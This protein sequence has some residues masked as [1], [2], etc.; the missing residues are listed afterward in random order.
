MVRKRADNSDY[1]C[2]MA[3]D[4]Y[5][6]KG[7]LKPLDGVGSMVVNNL[8]GFFL[9]ESSGFDNGNF[10]SHSLN[11]AL[12]NINHLSLNIVIPHCNYQEYECIFMSD[13]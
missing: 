3:N 2:L 9:I 8:I 7:N 1:V 13:Y 6:G 10:L 5:K 12:K 4:F 11:D